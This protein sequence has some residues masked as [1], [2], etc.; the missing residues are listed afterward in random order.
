VLLLVTRRVIL[1]ATF[2][3]VM[4]T[5]AV[6]VIPVLFDALQITVNALIAPN[7]LT[8]SKIV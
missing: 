6:N 7:D 4:F 2:T 8:F 3:G 1:S 5:S